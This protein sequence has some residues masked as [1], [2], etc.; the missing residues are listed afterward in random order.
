MLSSA[1]PD[2]KLSV[3]PVL[4]IAAQ[5]GKVILVG[6]AKEFYAVSHIRR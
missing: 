3:E 6:N 1:K 2:M 4:N 5:H